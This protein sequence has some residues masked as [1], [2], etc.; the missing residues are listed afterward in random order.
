MNIKNSIIAPTANIEDNATILNSKIG[1]F[2]MV[3][4]FSRF[5]YS[6]MEDF[7]YISQ[8]THVFSSQIGK[9]TSISWNV[10]IGPAN[11]DMKRFTSHAM[12]YAKRF[13]MIEQPFYNQYEGHVNIGNDVWIGCNSTIVRGGG[14]TIGDGA[15]IGANSVI[16]KDVPPYSVVCGVNKFIK[17]RFEEK[18]RNR[19]IEIAWWNY[20][21]EVIKQCIDIMA[22]QPSSDNIEELYEKLNGI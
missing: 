4:N 13:N 16:T 21:P 7:S 1:E 3:G 8:N 14:I 12:L 5:C 18:V 11:H 19:L 10:S 17:W 20:P 6:S 22:K 9:Y 2:C 15:V